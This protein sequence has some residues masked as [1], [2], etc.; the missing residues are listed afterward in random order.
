M[1]LTSQEAM[2]CQLAGLDQPPVWHVR[3]LLSMCGSLSWSCCS[4]LLRADEERSSFG[5]PG[6][7]W[8]LSE[9]RVA[10]VEE[11]GMTMRE[12]L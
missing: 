4:S 8:V 12:G 5:R 11:E 9:P 3:S 6:F 2:S 1:Y 7:E 10:L